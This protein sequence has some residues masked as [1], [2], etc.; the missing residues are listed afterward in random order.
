MRYKLAA[1]VE[2]E[3]LITMTKP[4]RVLSIDMDACLFNNP[5]KENRKFEDQ[6][7]RM[8]AK[9]SP[10]IDANHSFLKGLKKDKI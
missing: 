9:Y 5:Y 10:V 2:I 4:I 3:L 8:D 1:R 7:A 6:A